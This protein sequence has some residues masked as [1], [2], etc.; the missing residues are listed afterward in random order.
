MLN[1]EN[2]EVPCTIFPLDDE[3]VQVKIQTE[4]GTVSLIKEHD[5]CRTPGFKKR[6][7]AEGV[8]GMLVSKVL[9]E[10]DG[11][12]EVELDEEL[13]AQFREEDVEPILGE[14]LLMDLDGQNYTWANLSNAE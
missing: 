3:N 4:N 1:V 6:L 10:K 14:Y 9:S 12:V 5:T 13:S 7:L 8:K 2:V 11:I